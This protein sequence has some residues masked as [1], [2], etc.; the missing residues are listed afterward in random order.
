MFSKIKKKIFFWPKNQKINFSS[1]FDKKLLNQKKFFGPNFFFDVPRPA[2]L[3]VTGPIFFY[4][5]IIFDQNIYFTKK[6]FWP[7]NFLGPKN[8]IWPN[9]YFRPTF[10][11]EQTFCLS[12]KLFWPKQIF[13]PKK[14]FWPTI[15]FLPKNV[16]LP[17]IVLTNMFFWPKIF[18]D[19]TFFI[20]TR[21]SQRP[22]FFLLNLVFFYVQCCKLPVQIYS[23]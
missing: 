10:C 22:C 23:S 19:Q 21:F 12:K 9:N 13:R 2:L 3:T 7:K 4:Q 17:E 14:Q 1:F 6:L 8:Y 15:Y 18:W 20:C 5:I 11:F 16:F